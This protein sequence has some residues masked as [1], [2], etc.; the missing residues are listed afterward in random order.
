MI[1]LRGKVM[2][3]KELAGLEATIQIL[4][5]ADGRLMMSIKSDPR[6]G[7]YLA[8]VPAGRAYAMHV[9]ADGYLLHSE[10]IHAEPGKEVGMDI[11]L[12]S[13][14]AG[15]KEVMRNI[16]FER[17]QAMLD[18]A[19]L[20]EL[21]QVL[22]LLRDN[23]ALRLEIGGHTDSDGSDDH[24]DELSTRRAN[25]VVDHLVNNGI[26]PERLVAKGYGSVQPLVPN[27]SEANKAR[28]RRTEMR[29]L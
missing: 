26:P 13:M 8:V 22:T 25:A 4:D 9:Q 28:N 10:N 6:T 3:F 23:P 12:K 29:V 16:F 27:D 18:P 15:T 7:E 14:E 11:S 20:G 5:L 19:S 21:G 1:T 24:N 17:D 2:T